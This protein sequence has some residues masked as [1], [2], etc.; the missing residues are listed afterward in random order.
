[1]EQTRNIRLRRLQWVVHMMRMQ[2]EKVPR[3]A[4]KGCIEGRKL[5]GRPKGRW[6]DEVDV[7]MQELE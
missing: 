5:V 3:E 2:D 1:M 7:E 6:L 4:L